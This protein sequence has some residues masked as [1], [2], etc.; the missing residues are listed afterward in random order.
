MIKQEVVALS[1][2][3]LELVI[4]GANP[5]KDDNITVFIILTTGKTASFTCGRSMTVMDLK[6][7][8]AKCYGIVGDGIRLVFQGKQLED[9]DTLSSCGVE[10]DS[11]IHQLL[12]LM[13]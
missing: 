10:R 9:V 6:K 2:E 11:T 8:I 13:G 4:G 3:E 5:D 1:E 7:L 12:R